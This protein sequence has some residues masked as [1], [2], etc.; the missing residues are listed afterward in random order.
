MEGV[1]TN[2]KNLKGVK[3]KNNPTEN[4]GTEIVVLESDLLS[5][6]AK[7]GIVNTLLPKTNRILTNGSLNTKSVNFSLVI[8]IF[9][10]IMLSL[11]SLLCTLP[12][13]CVCISC[14]M[15]RTSGSL[16][17]FTGGVSL[18]FN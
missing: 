3:M 10:R 17:F 2:F 16:Y 14:K 8:I 7:L 1:N 13:P 9:K 4:Y 5:D 18:I 12:S 11:C 15:P 6:I